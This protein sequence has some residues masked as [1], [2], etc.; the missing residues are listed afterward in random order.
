MALKSTWVD[1]FTTSKKGAKDGNFIRSRGSL[2]YHIILVSK[3]VKVSYIPWARCSAHVMNSFIHH[4][5]NTYVRSN[6][7]LIYIVMKSHVM[8]SYCFLLVVSY[9]SQ[10]SRFCGVLR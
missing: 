6:F 8:N 9:Y 4:I 1:V 3:S 5:A 10:L 7:S 2:G